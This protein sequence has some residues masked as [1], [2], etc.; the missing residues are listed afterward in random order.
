MELNA[1]L[2]GG[3]VTPVEPLSLFS[4]AVNNTTGHLGT[5]CFVV[6]ACVVNIDIPGQLILNL[7]T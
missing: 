1:A 2:L 7:E 5:F 6:A 4:H 3:L